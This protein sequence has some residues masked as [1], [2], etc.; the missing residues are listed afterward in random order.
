MTLDLIRTTLAEIARPYGDKRTQHCRVEATAWSGKRCTLVGAVLDVDTATTLLLGLATRF[1]ATTF[2]TAGVRVLRAAEP[3]LLTVVTNLTS[4]HVGPSFLA[5]PL[6]Q[7]LNGW[8]LE[9]L[10]EQDLWAFVRLAD[11]YLGWTYL[12]YLADVP[13]PTPTH[14]VSEPLVLLHAAPAAESL[15]TGR[16]LAGTA[17]CIVDRIDAWTCLALAGGS[18]GWAPASALR[19][20]EVQPAEAPE[21]R[22]QMAAD[23]LRF[24][25]TPYLWGGGSTFGTDCSGFVQMVHRL[26]GL[27]LPRDADMQHAAGRPVTPPFRPGDLLFFGGGSGH[28]PI[29]HVGMSLGGWQMVHA[30][31]ARNGVYV[32]DVQTVP[33]LRDR[34]LAAVTFVG[35]S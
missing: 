8:R 31:R 12:P 18:M 14:L 21:R 9:I 10:E 23:A 26:S 4:L 32:D 11:G 35:P 5:E 13:A 20:P 28:R 19:D 24:L 3:R 1:P 17:V 16:L 7:L 27:T 15:L 30:S 34:F 33:H 25:G 29:S 2:D 6:S 22:G